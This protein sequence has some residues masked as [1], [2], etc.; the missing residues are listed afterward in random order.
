MENSILQNSLELRHKSEKNSIVSGI[1]CKRMPSHG[2]AKTIGS[3]FRSL[4]QDHEN[5]LKLQIP[6]ANIERS[7]KFQHPIMKFWPLKE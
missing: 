7:R 2:Y 5:N 4:R 3:D 1:A 6:S